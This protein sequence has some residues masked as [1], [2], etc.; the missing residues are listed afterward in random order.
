MLSVPLKISRLQA[1]LCAAMAVVPAVILLVIGLREPPQYVARAT[2]FFKE[3]ED[4]TSTLQSGLSVLSSLA[5]LQSDSQV[6]AEQEIGRITSRQN[7][8]RFVDGHQLR[9]RL[10][11]AKILRGRPDEL[12]D[13][14]F[15]SK[16]LR[17]IIDFTPRS[18]SH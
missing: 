5:G 6:W 17:N 14:E 15:V 2:L 10:V 13:A 18:K 4:R 1:A 3:P 11:N 8:Q 7:L 9:D 12:A 16:S